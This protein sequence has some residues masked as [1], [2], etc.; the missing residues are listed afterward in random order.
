[1]ASDTRVTYGGEI[2][3]GDNLVVDKVISAGGSYIGSSGWGVYDNILS[4]Y[5]SDK[6]APELGSEQSIF[7]F[8]MDLWRDL[9][10][11]YP[12]VNDQSGDKDSPFGDLDAKFLI[13]NA[14]GIFL[15][16]SNMS[17]RR[18]NKYYAI[19][20]GSSYSM[21]AMH[22]LYDGD[23]NAEAIAGRAVAAAIAFD[24]DCG[25]EIRVRRV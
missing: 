9:H 3:P 18:F 19:G 21:G 11:R 24:N 12:F 6:S 5:L 8:F 23:L 17:V 1:M 22:V 15:V 20:S 4:D 10:K 25:G 13:A 16:S 2:I 7:A 14:A